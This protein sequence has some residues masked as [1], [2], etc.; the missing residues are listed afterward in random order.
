MRYGIKEEVKIRRN[1]TVEEVKCFRYQNVVHFKQECPNIEVKRKKKK[2]E[3][4]V[5]VA[6]LQKAQQEKKLV[7]FLQKKAQEYSGI[8]GMF[9]RNAALEKRG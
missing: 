1:K 5:H 9:S 6:S 2:D 8:Q 4:A 3:E 7:Y